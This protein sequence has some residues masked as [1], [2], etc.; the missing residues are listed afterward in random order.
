MKLYKMLYFL[1]MFKCY[2]YCF[3]EFPNH[4]RST[5]FSILLHIQFLSYPWL[6]SRGCCIRSNWISH[7][8]IHLARHGNR[9]SSLS[10]W[11]QFC[12]SGDKF[13]LASTLNMPNQEN[14]KV[15]KTGSASWRHVPSRLSWMNISCLINQEEADSHKCQTNSQ[16]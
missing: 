8:L 15:N 10:I 2:Y 7:Q 3:F 9:M 6:S 4:F 14:F 5:N 12:R 1:H 16:Y 13:F 11:R